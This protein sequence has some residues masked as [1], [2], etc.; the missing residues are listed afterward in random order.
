MPDCAVLQAT[1]GCVPKREIRMKPMRSGGLGR[2]EKARRDCSSSRSDGGQ[3]RVKFLDIRLRSLANL[4]VR[5]EC[6]KR[7]KWS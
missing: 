1:T 7:E 5:F 4:L 2:V 6:L 3:A